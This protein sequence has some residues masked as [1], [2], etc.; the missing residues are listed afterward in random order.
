MR[1]ARVLCGIAG[2]ARSSPD[3]ARGGGGGGGG[4]RGRAVVVV[5][6]TAS[7]VHEQNLH[8]N[9]RN[10]LSRTYSDHTSWSLE[11]RLVRINYF[12]FDFWRNTAGGRDWG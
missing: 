7:S 6:R 5:G 10:S 11:E 1:S 3:T 8:Q 12:L 2:A 9:F 4:G